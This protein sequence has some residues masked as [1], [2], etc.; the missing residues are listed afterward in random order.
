MSVL[1]LYFSRSLA[2]SLVFDFSFSASSLYPPSSSFGFLIYP[3]YLRIFVD[4]QYSLRFDQ[5]V[6]LGS[7]GCVDISWFVGFQPKNRM[8]IEHETQNTEVRIG[9][10]WEDNELTL[11]N[12]GLRV[13]TSGL[14]SVM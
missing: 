1:Q 10:K 9:F 12:T 8:A 11:K 5:L 3:M 7:V 2:L 4:R 13:W 14:E 6:K